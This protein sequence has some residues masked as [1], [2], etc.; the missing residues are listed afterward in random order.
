MTGSSYS[1]HYSRYPNYRL[2]R[3]ELIFLLLCNKKYKG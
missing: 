2:Y 1:T 3:V